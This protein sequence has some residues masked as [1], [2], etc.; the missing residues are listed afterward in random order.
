MAF[1]SRDR[2]RRG[3]TLVELLVVIA[4][5]AILIGLLL[6]A[7]Q[8]VREA[9]ARVKCQNGMRQ[10]AIGFH[11]HHDQKL[12]FPPL[13]GWM[14]QN[15]AVGSVYGNAFYHILPYIE[16]QTIYD[17]G[18]GQYNDAAK[19]NP[20]ANTYS[21]G[22]TTYTYGTNPLPYM[23]GD[24]NTQY[25]T[26]PQGGSPYSGRPR[27]NQIKVLQCPSDGTARTDGMGRANTD[28]GASSIAFNAQVLATLYMADTGNAAGGYLTITPVY[29]KLP[30]SFADGTAKTI[31][32][33]DRLQSCTGAN[34]NP[35][36]NYNTLALHGGDNP[37]TP[38]VGHYRVPGQ[39]GYNWSNNTNR[40][41]AGTQLGAT[42]T[43][44]PQLLPLFS[45]M[46]PCDPT[47]ASSMHSGG[48]NVV[49]ADASTRFLNKGVSALSWWSALT[50]NGR[51]IS[52][53]DF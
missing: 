42:T 21:F 6:P 24:P 7:I 22:G 15:D 48:I 33:T 2:D 50:P 43:S 36:A 8:K 53:P 29:A 4:I 31:L 23:H 26:S 11:N 34:L 5:I 41:P 13:W 17:L 10:V 51:E 9:A 44:D 38:A 19:L 32:L 16:E 20:N 37:N 18:N 45:P 14:G 1:L 30:D 46:L 49:M 27:G 28:W 40:V 47:R 12:S 35:N 52:G 39:S 25:Y 3:F